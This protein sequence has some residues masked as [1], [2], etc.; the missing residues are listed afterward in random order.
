[1]MFHNLSEA[2][3]FCIALNKCSA[4]SVALVLYKSWLSPVRFANHNHVRV[5]IHTTN[6]S[7]PWKRWCCRWWIICNTLW[8]CLWKCLWRWW[9]NFSWSVIFF[10]F[11]LI[12]LS[13]IKVCITII[14]RN[15]KKS[16]FLPTFLFAIKRQNTTK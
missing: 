8:M 5:T 14:L 6:N 15:A 3:G 9:C 13:Q 16:K 2:L 12:Q 1:M 4:V 10:F 11:L 7:A